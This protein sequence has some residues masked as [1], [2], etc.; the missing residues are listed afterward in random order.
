MLGN[1]SR[2]SGEA[3]E[4][5]YDDFSRVAI[6]LG[7]NLG[8][9][10]QMLRQALVGLRRLL[11]DVRVSSVWETRPLGIRDQPQFLNACCTGRTRLPP[12]R[13]LS[14]L[15]ELE[16]AAGRSRDGQRFGP[17]TLDLDLL[18]YGRRVITE[19]DLI[20]PHPRLQE[21]A[22]VLL[23]LKEIAGDWRVPS[24]TSREERT[25]A[26]LASAVSISGVERTDIRLED[27]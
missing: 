24:P 23:P 3:P 19:A 25:V 12:R 8:D 15:Q 2:V 7:G 10:R 13:L 18:L 16:R 1:R 9:R 21:R 22:F 27:L 14:A 26:E 6:G 17:R 11:V 4:A 20:V 5:A